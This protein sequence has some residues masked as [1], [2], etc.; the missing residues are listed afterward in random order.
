MVRRSIAFVASTAL[1]ALVLSACAGSTSGA[2]GG[3][4][5]F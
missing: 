5:T 2:S 3:G 1:L 4:G